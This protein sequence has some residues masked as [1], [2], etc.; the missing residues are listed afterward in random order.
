MTNRSSF[1]VFR[2]QAP[3]LPYAAKTSV[4]QL[5]SR[6]QTALCEVQ[7]EFLYVTCVNVRPQFLVL[8]CGGL[9]CDGWSGTGVGCPVITW[10]FVRHYHS[11]SAQYFSVCLY[12]SYQK[13]VGATWTPPNKETSAFSEIR[14]IWTKKKYFNLPHE[15]V[16]KLAV[17]SFFFFV[18]ALNFL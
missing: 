3:L 14:Y 5:G 6:V 17:L 12:C 16:N 18:Q 9:G 7:T 8:H 15:S 10:V 4:W 11:P 13:D 2:F 1:V